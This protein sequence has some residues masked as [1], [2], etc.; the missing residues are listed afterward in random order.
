MD[1]PSGVTEFIKCRY[2]IDCSFIK[3]GLEIGGVIAGFLVEYMLSFINNMVRCKRK[4][5]HLLPKEDRG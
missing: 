2:R 3:Y 1:N 5:P 4:H